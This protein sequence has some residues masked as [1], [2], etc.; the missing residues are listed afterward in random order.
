[1]KANRRKYYVEVT[2]DDTRK[3]KTHFWKVT[4]EEDALYQMIGRYTL[5]IGPPKK[6]QT[7]TDKPNEMLEF[8]KYYGNEHY[9]SVDIDYVLIQ[10][11]KQQEKTV[12]L[13]PPV[14]EEPK[15]EPN[16]VTMRQLLKAAAVR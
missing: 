2:V 13:V 11:P 1:M 3:A 16:V 12:V 5:Q 4:L 6:V 14:V 9:L 8:Y 10:E 15:P 7:I